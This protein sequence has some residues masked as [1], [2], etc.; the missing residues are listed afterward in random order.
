M[1]D[2]TSSR[3]QP[4][5][6]S[7][8]ICLLYSSRLQGLRNSTRHHPLKC[9]PR[10]STHLNSSSIR[11]PSRQ[12]DPTLNSSSSS[13]SSKPLPP[14]PCSLPRSTKPSSP[15][16][17]PHP[18]RYTTRPH[19]PSSTTSSTNNSSNLST[20]KTTPHQQPHNPT[21]ST[22]SS[23]TTLTRRT[24]CPTMPVPPCTLTASHQMPPDASWPTSSAPSQATRLCAS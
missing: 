5:S 24:T 3:W 6:S 16:T 10:S 15:S 11:Q 19:H 12:R 21:S 7:S 17:S 14:G 8:S 18:S 2:G 23:S 22:S 4:S 1:S 20:G 9:C 13:S